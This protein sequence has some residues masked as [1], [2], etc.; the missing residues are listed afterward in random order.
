MPTVLC[1]VFSLYPANYF[2]EWGQY[3]SLWSFPVS[4]YHQG[5][6]IEEQKSSLLTWEE[7]WFKTAT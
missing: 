5:S 7:A 6:E 2:T 1:S 3:F 4:V